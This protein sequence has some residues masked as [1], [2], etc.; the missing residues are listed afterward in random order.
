MAAATIDGFTGQNPEF[1]PMPG[2]QHGVGAGCDSNQAAPWGEGS[3]EWVPSC[4]PDFDLD[5]VKYP[6]GGAFQATPVQHVPTI[7]DALTGANLPWRIY[8]GTGPVVPGNP[9]D[10]YIWAVCPSFAQ[11]LYTDE[12]DSFVPNTDII[13]DAANG[14]LPANATATHYR[15]PA[16]QAL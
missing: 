15:A 4:V 6:Y 10:G 3:G 5:P 1:H 8:G 12:V 11:C 9:L 13:D 7:F 14:T 16:D 2:L